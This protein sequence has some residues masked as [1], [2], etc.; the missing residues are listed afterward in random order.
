MHIQLLRYAQGCAYTVH[1]RRR[2]RRLPRSRTNYHTKVRFV[3]AHYCCK[4]LV[5]GSLSRNVQ[6]SLLTVVDAEDAMLPD[7]PA[8]LRMMVLSLRQH[9]VAYQKQLQDV[10]KQ[11]VT[12]TESHDAVLLENKRLKQGAAKVSE[13]ST[14]LMDELKAQTQYALERREQLLRWETEL[15]YVCC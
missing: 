11:L 5:S 13:R 4:P 3:I 7:D 1:P 14:A 9:V 8:Q 10:Q 15:R 2:T 6:T 12:L